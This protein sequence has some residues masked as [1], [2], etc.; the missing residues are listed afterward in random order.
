LYLV[1]FNILLNYDLQNIFVSKFILIK[2]L[3]VKIKNLVV[4]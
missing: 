1:F 4:M 2:N 3:V